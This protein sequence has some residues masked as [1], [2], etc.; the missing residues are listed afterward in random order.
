MLELTLLLAAGAVI[1]FV[2]FTRPARARRD[3]TADA[4]AEAVRRKL[5]REGRD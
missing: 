2:I 1:A 3:K 4:A 5:E